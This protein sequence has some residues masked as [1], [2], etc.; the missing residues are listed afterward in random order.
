M[1]THRIVPRLAKGEPAA[2]RASGKKHVTQQSV[3][4]AIWSIVSFRQACMN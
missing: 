4:A 1:E 2:T 3:D